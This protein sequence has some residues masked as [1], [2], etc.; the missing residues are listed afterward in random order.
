MVTVQQSV[1]QGSVLIAHCNGFPSMQNSGRSFSYSVGAER[2][3]SSKQIPWALIIAEHLQTFGVAPP[4]LVD[5]LYQ[6]CNFMKLNLA[7]SKCKPIFETSVS[8]DW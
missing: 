4:V 1:N 3:W 7:S 8:S 6:L 2:G 5:F